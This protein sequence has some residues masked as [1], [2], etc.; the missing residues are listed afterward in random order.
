LKDDT[1]LDDVA[2]SL[3]TDFA[4]IEGKLVLSEGQSKRALRDAIVVLAPANDTTRRITSKPHTVQADVE[5]R[6]NFTCAPGEY[7]V[8]ALT[9]A[10]LKNLALTDEYFR[11]D[12]KKFMRIKV[13]GADKLKELKIPI[14]VN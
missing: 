11:N 6:F 5:G 2:V 14:A 12:T 8:V 3:A 13:R 4:S 1:V 10:Q 9:P 7:F